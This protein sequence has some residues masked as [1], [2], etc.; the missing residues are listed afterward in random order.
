V[1]KQEEYYSVYEMARRMKVTPPTVY[2]W[3]KDG[4]KTTKQANGRQVRQ[5]V[6]DSD[7]KDFLMRNPE[8][9]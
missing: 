6:T 3:I 4:L 7:V 1:D 5:V 2:R 8:L 9:Q